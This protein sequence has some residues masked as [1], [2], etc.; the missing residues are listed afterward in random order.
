M[1]DEHRWVKFT[2]RRKKNTIA[3][4]AV[5]RELAGWTRSLAMMDD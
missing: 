3:N 5:A 4:V 2:N 1:E